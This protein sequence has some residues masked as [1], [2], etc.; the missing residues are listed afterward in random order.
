MLELAM[1]DTAL[2]FD[3]EGVTL[4]L[5]MG[6]V[7]DMVLDMRDVE[8]VMLNVVLDVVLDMLMCCWTC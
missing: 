8:D 5:D 6:D 4:E 2:E 7:G 3:A 1:G